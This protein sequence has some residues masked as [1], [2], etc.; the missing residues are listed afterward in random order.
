MPN[1]IKR[2]CGACPD[3]VIINTENIKD[4]LYYGS[5]YYHVQ[6]FCEKAERMSKSKSKNKNQW[7][8]A[9]EHIQD[10]ELDAKDK[11]EFP[12]NRDNFNEYLLMTYD[13]IKVPDRLWEVTGA[14]M[15][16]MYK[17]KR[18]K[19]VSIKILH[20]TWKWHQVELNKTN[21]Y[22]K[23]NH[24]GPENDEQRILYD[25]AIVVGNVKAYLTYRAK[26]DLLQEKPK[27]ET[28]F[29]HINYDDMVR[30]EVE[31]EGLDDISDLLDE[32]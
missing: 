21:T 7:K 23:M 30:M 24:R 22:N 28:K 11:L 2:K 17:C 9:L 20:E 10:F 32:F 16:G 14:L 29:N 8:D 31:H 1:V 4:V 18:C 12:K 5:S 13:V 6:C 3:K 26:M 15:K 27:E 25:L 19:P